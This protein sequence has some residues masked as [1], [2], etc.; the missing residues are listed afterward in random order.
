MDVVSTTTLNNGQTAKWK[1]KTRAY[2]GCQAETLATT[3][4]VTV[5]MTC[6]SSIMKVCIKIDHLTFVHFRIKH[7]KTEEDKRGE[8]KRAAGTARGELLTATMDLLF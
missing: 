7:A 6:I 2:C 1:E 5:K 8:A 4:E 3:S